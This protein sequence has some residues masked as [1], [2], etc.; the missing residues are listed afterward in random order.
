MKHVTRR[1]FIR[2]STGVAALCAADL[3]FLAQI[4]HSAASDTTIRQGDVTFGPE[5]DRLL[6]LIRTTS[7]EECVPAFAREVKAGLSYRQFLTVL[8]LAAVEN[9]DPHQV[10]QVYG[11]HR[12]STDARVEERLLPLFWVL[13]R[14]KQESGGKPNSAVTPF[15]SELPGADRAAGIFREALLKSDAAEAERAAL[16]LARDHGP[17]Y[18]MHRLWEFSVRNVGG[19][20]GHTAIAHANSLRA[21]EVMGWHHAEV[22]LRYITRY[23]AGQKGDK[24]YTA[25]IERLKQTSSRLPVNWARA[26]SN[27]AATVELYKLLRGGNA[28]ESCD[29]ICSQLLSGKATAGSVWDA[30]SLAAADSVSRHKAGGAMIGGQIHA[31]TTTNALRYGFNLV[32]DPAVRLINLLQAAGVTADF[33]IRHFSKEGALRDMNL[34]DLKSSAGKPTGT[35]GDVFESLPFKGREYTQKT[36]DERAA[37]DQACRMTLELLRNESNQAPFMQTARSFLCVKASLDPHDIK[38]PAAVFEDAYS[39]SAE[40]R[41]YLLASSVHSLHGTRS[42]DTPVL[43]QVKNALN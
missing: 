7:R 19:T 27:R 39:V 42:N 40:W 3:S 31:V 16:A 24:T 17:R 6:R 23:I 37:S 36:P 32:E 38:Y 10:A 14:I 2:R 28:A 26:E 11:A 41:P 4:S 8:F 1:N 25:N 18:V 15:K 34:L 30:I 9:G 13:N 33:F 20:L 35:I 43:V 22:A 5:T 21:L 29:L 12:V